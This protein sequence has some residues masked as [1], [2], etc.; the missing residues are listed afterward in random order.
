[1]NFLEW[2]VPREKRFFTMLGEESANIVEGTRELAR[3]FGNGGIA[4]S[5]RR[6]KEIEAHGD[7][8]VHA[9]FFELN[10]TFITP[11]DHGDLSSL[12]TLMDDVLDASYEAAV[13]AELYNLRKK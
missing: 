12:A 8:L 1:M 7:E 13:R 4:A 5:S 11:I 9:L 10:K 2:I 3:G 6:L